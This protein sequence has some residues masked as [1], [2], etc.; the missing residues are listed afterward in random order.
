MKCLVRVFKQKVTYNLYLQMGQEE[1]P[2]HICDMNLNKETYDF[3]KSLLKPSI[4]EVTDSI[5]NLQDWIEN[6]E[7]PNLDLLLERM[8]RLEAR[9]GTNPRLEIKEDF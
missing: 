7:E 9:I 1:S 2:L 3:F 8:L 4:K 6:E 5:V